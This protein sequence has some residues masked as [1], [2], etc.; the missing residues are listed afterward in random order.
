MRKFILL[1][2]SIIVLSSCVESGES[3][4]NNTPNIILITLD[5]VRWQEVF[6][7]V[8]LE[9]I[10]NKKFTKNSALLKEMFLSDDN[11]KRQQK[12]L[13]FFGNYI[14]NKGILI[15]NKNE[16]SVL[17]LTNDQLFSYPGYNEI[18]TGFADSSITGFSI[19]PVA[20]DISPLPFL[21]SS[22]GAIPYADMTPPTS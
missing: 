19:N 16:G 20:E 5:G 1:L 8:D 17:K 2:I 6:N 3:N 22:N 15:G 11:K 9:L 10:E 12:L 4:D 13:P 21:S 18:L 14:N 7:G